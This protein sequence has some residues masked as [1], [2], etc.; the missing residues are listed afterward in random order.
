MT[1]FNKEKLGE[2]RKNRSWQ[3][4]L[5]EDEAKLLRELGGDPDAAGSR[6]SGQAVEKQREEDQLAELFEKLSPGELTRIYV[7]DR[8]TWQRMA[9]AHE[10]K[11]LRQ[12]LD[13]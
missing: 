3:E 11:G 10:R 7:E 6:S 12:L 9:D 13:T 2:L 5:R 8:D 4:R 1:D